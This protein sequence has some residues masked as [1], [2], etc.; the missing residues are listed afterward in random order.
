[1]K[2]IAARL[3]AAITVA[4]LL[5]LSAMIAWENAENR[6]A[7]LDQARDFAHS[8]HEMTLAGLTG[9]MITGTVGQREVFL[10]QI[11]Q[12]D[13]VRELQVTRGE[14]VSRMFGPGNAGEQASDPVIAEVMRSGQAYDRVAEDANGEYL[15]IV[16]PALASSNY[17]GKDCIA[18]HQV[19]EG[20]VLGV[21]SMK[22]SLAKVGDAISAQRTKLA[23]AGLVLC[24]GMFLLV[25]FFIR[26]FVAQPLAAMTT[27]L[28]LIASGEGD[29][30]HRLPVGKNDE[31]GQ[32]SQAF[33]LMMDKFAGLV[34]QISRTAGEV[35]LATG[36]LASIAGEVA[37]ASQGQQ[38]RSLETTSAVEE[39]AAGVASIAAVADRV[40][41]QSQSNLDDARRGG[42]NL[43]SL[44]TSMGDVRQAVEGIVASVGQ[45][46]AST[47]SI[48]DMTRQVKDIAEQTN[49][50][51]LNAAIEAAR[52]G[53]QGRGFAVV[54]D[55]VRKLAEKSGSSAS[56]IDQV[57]QQI[58]QQSATVMTA[59]ERG[60]QH[61]DRSQSDVDSVA[62]VLEKTAAGI[63]DVDAG[64]DQIG[65]ATAEQQ[66]ASLSASANI[67]QIAAMAARNSAA[68]A[69]VVAS[70]RA[71]EVHADGLRDVVGKF[72]LGGDAT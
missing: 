34:R 17:L 44:L 63:R 1:M 5:S 29:L 28:S 51:A 42:A 27:G 6:S 66:A 35:R 46:V 8:I 30:E 40:R 64:V 26:I 50:L 41:C 7:A 24:G 61:L 39:V 48:N 53:D 2:T 19:P 11:K 25:F 36:S 12:L 69:G 37:E 45:F 15:H 70:V 59:I 33:N 16:R 52:A 68:V 22:V 71:L 60:L 43:A 47:R 57:T 14:A 65:E 55:E 4:L 72:H 20:T 62:S 54:A 38:A 32:A 18:C 31:V 13:S 56:A 49:L 23:L 10:D 58:A 21:V 3:T 9:M 67:E